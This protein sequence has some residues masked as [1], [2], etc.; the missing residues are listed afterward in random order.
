MVNPYVKQF[1]VKQFRAAASMIS[2]PRMA[3]LKMVLIGNRNTDGRTYNLPSAP[4]V[5]ALIVGDDVSALQVRAI[6]LETSSG[7]L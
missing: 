1:H 3:P 6:V 7:D 2:V 4:E 5:A